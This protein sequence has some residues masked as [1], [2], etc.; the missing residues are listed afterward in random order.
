M[1]GKRNWLKQITRWI[2][3]S[4]TPQGE[5]K[6]N[7]KKNIEKNIEQIESSAISKKNKE[8]QKIKS[9]NLLK[10]AWKRFIQGWESQG[11]KSESFIQGNLLDQTV[12][13]LS[14]DE[15]FK[16]ELIETLFKI[17]SDQKILESLAEILKRGRVAAGDDINA[18]RAFAYISALT[19][20][21]KKD[22]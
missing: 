11:Y 12:N 5:K 20:P 16:N 2:F 14:K 3:E 4:P 15:S 18:I 21:E 22:Y 19:V 10:E 13:S 7:K 17:S 1:A 8:T 6:K 9:E